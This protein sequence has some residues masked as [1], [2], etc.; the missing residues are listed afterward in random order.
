M[1][2]HLQFFFKFQYQMLSQISFTNSLKVLAGLW[3]S[4]QEA[5]TFKA[6]VI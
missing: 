1:I 4:V 2:Q 5:P 6:T 3:I